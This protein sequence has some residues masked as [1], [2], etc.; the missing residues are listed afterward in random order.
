MITFSRIISFSI[1]CFMLGACGTAN[2]PVSDDELIGNWELSKATRNGVETETLSG[3]F[4]HF[5][6]NS[7]KTNL[8]GID[9]ADLPYA[10]NG[11]KVILNQSKDMQL[12]VVSVDADSLIIHLDIKEIDFKLWFT[13]M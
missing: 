1:F 8:S 12:D 5:N 7:V 6:E 11:S 9:T 4:L 2:E 10:I 13:K 3:L